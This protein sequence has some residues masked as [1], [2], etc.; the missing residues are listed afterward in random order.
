MA[1]NRSRS[2]LANGRSLTLVGSMLCAAAMTGGCENSTP[3]GPGGDRSGHSAAPSATTP[4]AG[5]QGKGNVDTSSR[6][7]AP[8]AANRGSPPG[9]VTPLGP[10]D[11]R[12]VRISIIL[13]ESS[14]IF[15]LGFLAG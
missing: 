14:S 10:G 12:S 1:M 5:N 13:E 11:R 3:T 2:P 8:E 4:A 9:E 15:V 7:R 6:R